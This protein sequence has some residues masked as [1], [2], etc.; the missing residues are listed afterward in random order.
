MG[1]EIFS[2]QILKNGNIR[3]FWEGRC[4]MTLG[5]NRAQKLARDL[6]NAEEG[7]IQNLLQR[8]TGNFKRG[9]ERQSLQQ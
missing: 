8:V 1:H 3:I 7:E 2:Y 9:N 4:V 6:N 5:G